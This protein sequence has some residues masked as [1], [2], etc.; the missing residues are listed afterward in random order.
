MYWIQKRSILEKKMNLVVFYPEEI[1][2]DVT[3][4]INQDLVTLNIHVSY[5]CYRLFALDDYRT[6]MQDKQSMVVI[7]F[8]KDGVTFPMGLL[9]SVK[10]CS[11]LWNLSVDC[12]WEQ[13]ITSD[14]RPQRQHVSMGVHAISLS[15]PWNFTST[16]SC[17]YNFLNQPIRPQLLIFG[18][19]GLFLQ[20]LL[21]M[22]VDHWSMQ[23]CKLGPLHEITTQ[24]E[25][26]LSTATHVLYCASNKDE[27]HNWN[28]LVVPFL[29]GTLT[30]QY[31]LHM[32]FVYSPC[33]FCQHKDICLHNSILQQSLLL[34]QSCFDH[35]L[36]VHHQFSLSGFNMTM[37]SFLHQL[38]LLKSYRIPIVSVLDDILPLLLDKLR[39]FETGI[40]TG[41]NKHVIVYDMLDLPIV[42]CKTCQLP[43]PP[44]QAIGPDINT[45]LQLQLLRFYLRRKKIP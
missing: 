14:N 21:N 27:N 5:H 44:K 16:R 42:D 40:C 23:R 12:Y 24:I 2:F 1:P 22:P 20:H 39:Q 19:N 11:K 34:L 41:V 13:P 33:E 26:H 43:N 31:H 10:T 15:E 37:D 38:S 9:Q 3:H 4:F 8:T 29:L 32:T 7:V 28:L 18:N 6:I 36:F 45:S 35:I 25:E 30:K 17:L